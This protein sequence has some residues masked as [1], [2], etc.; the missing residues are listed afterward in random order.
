VILGFH[1][2]KEPGVD[3]LS[4]RE[5]VEIQLHHIIYE[6]IDQVTAAMVGLLPPH[7]EERVMGRAEIRQ[8]FPLGKQGRVAGCLVT[9]GAVTPRFRVR[10]KRGAEVL[11]EGAIASLRH[12]QQDAAEIRQTQECGIRL[13][14]FTGF[15][16]GDTLEFYHLEEKKQ[17]L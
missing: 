6:L 4:K 9:E 15:E 5:G 13:E 11:Y 17:T 14:N 8:V 12:F 3:G 1:V 10:V 7:I 16:A 2:A